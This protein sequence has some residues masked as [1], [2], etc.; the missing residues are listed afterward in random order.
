[1]TTKAGTANPQEPKT[2]RP[3]TSV[4]DA[5]CQAIE[6]R[7]KQTT[8]HA[9]GHL[10]HAGRCFVVGGMALCRCKERAS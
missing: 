3:D 1:M 2:L 5:R 8:C 10:V 6:P 4:I 7:S 9:C